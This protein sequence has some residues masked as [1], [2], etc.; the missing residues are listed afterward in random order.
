LNG[1]TTTV[2]V[3]TRPRRVS[4]PVSRPFVLPSSASGLAVPALL[5]FSSIT[6]SVAFLTMVYLHTATAG[7]LN[8]VSTTVSDLIFADGIGWLFAVSAILLASASVALT[9]A[10]VRTRLPGRSLISVI[11]CVWSLGL[12]LASVLPTDPIG[13]ETLSVAGQIHR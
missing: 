4:R 6:L 10:L 7:E 5:R 3:L 8:P 12:L 1:V 9:I 2:S 13:V 11:L